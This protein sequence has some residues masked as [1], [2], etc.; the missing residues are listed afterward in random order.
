MSTIASSSAPLDIHEQNKA[1]CCS[2]DRHNMIEI[3]ALLY[4]TNSPVDFSCLRNVG[5]I[6]SG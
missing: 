5:K 1:V 2:Q 4:T 3:I 6:I